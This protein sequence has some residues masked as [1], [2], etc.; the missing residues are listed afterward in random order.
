[1]SWLPLIVAG[2]L[3]VSLLVGYVTVLVGI[4][5]QDRAMTLRREVTGVS[6]SLARRVTGCHVRDGVQWT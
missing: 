1:M 2:L 6:A 4:R 5:R 3:G